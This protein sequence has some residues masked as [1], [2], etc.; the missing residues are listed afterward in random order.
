MKYKNEDII[1]L[2]TN[3]LQILPLKYVKNYLRIDNDCDDELLINAIATAINYAEYTINKVFGSKIYRLTLES[4][5]NILQID[6]LPLVI[7]N[8]RSLTVNDKTLDTTFYEIHGGI[9]IMK[10]PIF[11]K[12]TVVFEA[13]IQ[14]GEVP[15][16]IRQ[17]MLFH[18]ASIYQ[19]KDG[20][21][22]APKATQEIYS[23]YR[24]I[25]V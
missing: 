2:E 4:D 17:A 24:N 3:A 1:V 15:V 7:S 19:N 5:S 9:I 23:L 25:R 18:V 21:A 20:N 14:L 22:I 12:I 11:G 6:K 16:D 8:V 10:T 13:G